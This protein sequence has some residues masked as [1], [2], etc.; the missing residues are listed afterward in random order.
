MSK[1][2]TSTEISEQDEVEADEL[3]APEEFEVPLDDMKKWYDMSRDELVEHIKATMSNDFDVI[4]IAN[5]VGY[6][7]YIVRKDRSANILSVCHIDTVVPHKDKKFELEEADAVGG[8]KVHILHSPHNDD[9]QGLATLMEL[10]PMHDIKSDFLICDEE[11]KGNTTSREFVSWRKALIKNEWKDDDEKEKMEPF[12]KYGQI[13]YNWL[14]E[15]DRRGNDV[16]TYSYGAGFDDETKAFKESLEEFWGKG[17][18]SRGS[19]TDICSLTSL[20]VKAFNVGVGYENAHAR[21]GYFVVE[22]FAWAFINFINFYRKYEEIKFPHTVKP[23]TTSTT[24]GG[25]NYGS[26]YQS[27]FPSRIYQWPKSAKRVPQ[28]TIPS[29][30]LWEELKDNSRIRCSVFPEQVADW[31]SDSY[32]FMSDRALEILF[33]FY[34]I[35]FETRECQ[36]CG[37]KICG[38]DED[39]NVCTSCLVAGHKYYSTHD[40]HEHYV[41]VD[42][43]KEVEQDAGDVC[44]GEIFE[45]ETL[46]EALNETGVIGDW[47]QFPKIELSDIMDFLAGDTPQP[48]SGCGHV[49]DPTEYN[50]A[51]VKSGGRY[52][53]CTSCLD[54]YMDILG[55][56]VGM[57]TL[58]GGTCLQC[59]KKTTHQYIEFVESGKKSFGCVDMYCKGCHHKNHPDGDDAPFVQYW[60]RSDSGDVVYTDAAGNFIKPGKISTKKI[61]NN[62]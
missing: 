58:L 12:L 37:A 45:P 46:A 25:G 48:C 61:M 49:I 22:K 59:N 43:K 18:T 29:N 52:L 42:D 60:K 28:A 33:D 16:A 17:N 19:F 6:C 30:S 36:V 13:E 8:E 38:S 32:V 34:E 15:F 24:Y 62:D 41:P 54:V 53:L 5:P 39:D 35:E 4:D 31:V 57:S 47:S 1:T 14:V 44:D 26:S 50:T 7:L 20:G 51:I 3:F 55:V 10:Y 27:R 11:E 23:T 9:R 56:K 2:M 21:N 40:S